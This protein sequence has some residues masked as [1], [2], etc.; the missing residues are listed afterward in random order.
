MFRI[1]EIWVSH[2]WV[3]RALQGHTHTH[4]HTHTL[5]QTPRA[6]WW[7]ALL[8]GILEPNA[9]FAQMRKPRLRR[10][11]LVPA[12]S[13][14][15]SL[16]FPE[17]PW[18]LSF[19]AVCVPL[20]E[21]CPPPLSFPLGW[22]KPWGLRQQSNQVSSSG[23]EDILWGGV[24]RAAFPLVWAKRRRP[25]APVSPTYQLPASA[26]LVCQ[27]ASGPSWFLLPP[28]LTS[29]EGA[30]ALQCLVPLEHHPS[31]LSVCPSLLW[32]LPKKKESKLINPSYAP[33]PLWGTWHTSF[34]FFFFILW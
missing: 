17:S 15:L 12:P 34:I 22:G 24:L 2:I 8:L 28:T 3:Q 19:W 13:P 18:C 33:D 20:L 31:P 26:L 14:Y 25:A 10:A 16:S 9:L 11:E 1:N 23:K 32:V 21:V 4:T 27:V 6:C 29:P 5:S 7:K 30:L